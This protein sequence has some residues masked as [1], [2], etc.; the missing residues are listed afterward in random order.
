MRFQRGVTAPP[1]LVSF[2]VELLDEAV[3]HALIEVLPA[4]V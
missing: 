2:P 4:W 3:D 1:Y